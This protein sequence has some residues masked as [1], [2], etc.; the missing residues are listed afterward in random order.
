MTAALLLAIPG[1]SG[2][3]STGA[4]PA[5][6]HVVAPQLVPAPLRHPE[7]ELPRVSWPEL[8]SPAVNVPS[9]ERPRLIEPE[10]VDPHQVDLFRQK[11]LIVDV[12][13]VVDNSGSMV[14]ERERLASSFEHFVRLLATRRIDYHVGVIS[15]DVTGSGP[16]R[17]GG[18]LVEIDGVRFITPDTPDGV[19]VFRAMVDFEPGRSRQEQGFEAMRLALSE[20]RRSGINGGFLRPESAL[21]VVVVSDEDDGSFGP[22]DHFARFLLHTRR[23]GDE[24]LATLS[25][26]V[27][28]LPDGCVPEGEAQIFGADADPAER[29]I[30]ASQISGG[31]VGSICETDFAPV[32]EALGRRVSNLQ[33]TFPLSSVPQIETLMVRIDGALI[34]PEEAEGPVWTYHD[35]MRA[36]VFEEQHIPGSGSEVR[37]AYVVNTEFAP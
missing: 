1:C 35:G 18:E 34:A 17:Q 16:A 11:T 31:L 14:N 29:Y 28:P 6:P 30:E 8:A 24:R 2:G 23:P 33:R 27:G 37:V 13:W 25:A 10:L 7:V 19:E 12:L 9:L 5:I 4:R 22:P 3:G 26:I 15:T 36:I 20:P 32:L 21:A